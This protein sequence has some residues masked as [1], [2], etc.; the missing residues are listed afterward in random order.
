MLRFLARELHM[1]R[2]MHASSNGLVRTTDR[3]ESLVLAT[4]SLAA[5]VGLMIALTVG[6]DTYAS[7]KEQV[8]AQEPRH[9]VSTTVVD[10]PVPTTDAPPH[11]VVEWKGAD[12]GKST[13]QIPRDRFD[14]IGRERVVWLDD[15]GEVVDPPLTTANAVVEAF[16]AGLA[17]IVITVLGW[18]GLTAF[19]RSLADRRRYRQWDLEWRELDID[20]HR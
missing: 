3:V 12:G 2:L 15:E 13:A 1:W 19:V 9:S 6:A 17:I 5:L 8:D 18:C 11:V 4:V 10:I 16:L 7:H 14:R 20:S